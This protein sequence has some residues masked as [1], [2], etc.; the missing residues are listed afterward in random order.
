MRGLWLR[1]L[2]LLC[3]LLHCDVDVKIVFWSWDEKQRG[4]ILLGRKE[5]GV[6]VTG[7]GYMPLGR[8]EED[9]LCYGVYDSCNGLLVK[10]K[11]RECERA[12]ELITL[13]ALKRGGATLYFSIPSCN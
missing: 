3:W 13:T 9:C 1:H 12:I 5:E 8:K 7:I 10:Y 2:R 11:N 6:F 4:T